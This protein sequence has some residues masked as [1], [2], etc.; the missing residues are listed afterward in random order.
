MRPRRASQLGAEWRPAVLVGLFGSSAV[1]VFLVFSGAV[2]SLTNGSEIGLFLTIGMVFV[3]G[4]LDFAGVMVVV[5][6]I[7]RRGRHA[8]TI[9]Q[10]RPRPDPADRSHE[11]VV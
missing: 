4:L 7:Q 3:A 10:W 2:F 5:R 8:A 9:H 1:L 11:D 6:G